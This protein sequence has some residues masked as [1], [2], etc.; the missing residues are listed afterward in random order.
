MFKDF[1]YVPIDINENNIPE[2]QNTGSNFHQKDN[3]PNVISQSLVMESIEDN[4]V[5]IDLSVSINEQKI[6]EKIKQLAVQQICHDV[7]R[8]YWLLNHSWG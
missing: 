3:K 7:L 6:Q 2:F 4:V 8:W 1:N 5:A